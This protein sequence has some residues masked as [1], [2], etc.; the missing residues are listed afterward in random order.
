MLLTPIPSLA[1]F[2]CSNKR[3]LL[4]PSYSQFLH[5][6]TKTASCFSSPIPRPPQP[7]ARPVEIVPVLPQA[8]GAAGGA[9]DGAGT[10][11]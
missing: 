2:G 4:K 9:A 1:P 5:Q 6:P 10:H 11:R 7:L 8:D 3:H